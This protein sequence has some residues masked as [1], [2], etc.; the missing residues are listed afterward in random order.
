MKQLVAG[1]LLAVG[2][3]LLAFYFAP[4]RGAVAPRQ[5]PPELREEPDLYLEEAVIHQY[6]DDGALRYRLKARRTL[7]FEARQLTRVE[8][9]DF[10]L[11]SPP[12][13]PWRVQAQ[14]G[15]MRRSGDAGVAE[16]TVVLRGD[17]VLQ[18]VRGEADATTIRTSELRLHPE[19]RH[20][21]TDRS[22]MIESHAGRTA[23][24]GLE[25]DLG[26]RFLRLKSD[27][28]GQVHTVIPPEL[29]VRQAQDA[30]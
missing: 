3:L 16:E 29:F 14:Q 7:H 5:P 1:A 19:R 17:V 20:A 10:T 15:L 11:Y 28:D 24:Q 18:Q 30:G 9:P 23:A 8:R 26:S 25:A 22:V 13:P 2:L 12:Q 4:W 21:E 27:A 6:R